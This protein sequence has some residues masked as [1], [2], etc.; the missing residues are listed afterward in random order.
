[1]KAMAHETPLNFRQILGVSDEIKN[2]RQIEN[3]N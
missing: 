1:M 3:E 2:E